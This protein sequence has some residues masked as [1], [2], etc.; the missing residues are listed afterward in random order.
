[1][2]LYMEPITAIIVSVLL[3]WGWWEVMDD[4]PVCYVQEQIEGQ[5][6][7]RPVPCSDLTE[8]K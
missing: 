8:E 7:Y 5:T 6:V 2:K 1:M 4:G 3:G